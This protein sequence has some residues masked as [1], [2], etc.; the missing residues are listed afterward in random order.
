MIKNLKL[1]SCLLFF[2][3]CF[4]WQANGQTG[5]SSGKYANELVFKFIPQDDEFY[6]SQGD[7]KAVLDRLYAA[8]EK[9]KDQIKAG[10][11]P[12]LVEGYSASADT[13]E[14]NQQIAYR[15]AYRVKSVIIND[16]GLLE[17]NFKTQNKTVA[18]RGDKDVVVVRLLLNPAVQ[19]SDKNQA[20]EQAYEESEQQA[21][22]ESLSFEDDDV[23]TESQGVTT[24]AIINNDIFRSKAGFQL[25]Q[26]RFQKRGYYSY[27]SKRYINGVAFNDQNRGVFNYASIGALNDVARNGDAVDN[28]DYGLFSYGAL[29][30]AENIDMRAGSYA[31]GAKISASYTNRTYYARTMFTYST[32]LMPNGWAFTGSLGARYS[33]EGN[34]EGTFYRNIAYSLA[35]EKQWDKGRH[36]LSF[37]TFG[38]PVERGQQASSYL[39]TYNL[40]GNNLYNSNWG[41]Q[42]GKKRN[43]RIV[44]AYDPTF[45]L[46]H[47]WNI[48]RDS[49]LITG[50]GY[51]YGR[52]GSTSLNWYNGS[53]PRPDYYRYL[54]SYYSSSSTAFTYYTD[55]WMSNDPS[56]TQINWDNLYMANHNSSLSGQPAAYNVEERR[57]DLYETTLNSTLKTRLA[58]NINFVGGV[59]FRST[60]SRQFKT[61][62]DLLGGKYILDVDKFAEA[63][64]A[65][66]EDAKQSDLNN[67]NRKVYKG[68]TYGYS[69]DLDINSANAWF[70]NEHT[71]KKW[72]VF[73]G[74]KYTYTQFQ[75]D[76]K[77]KNGHY[78]D[79]SLGK[80]EMHRFHD[81]SFKAGLTY[82]FNGRNFISAKI[83]YSTEA[84]LP[85]NSYVSPRITD[86]TLALES[87]KLL[88][89]D[90]SYIFSFPNLNGRISAY[91]TNF[92][93][94]TAR[95]SYYHD[96]KRTFVNHM[97]TGMDK[98][99]HGVE[100]GLSWKATSALTFDFAG[101]VS[102]Q[103]Y[104]NNPMG[105]ITY[106]NGS[107]PDV[108]EK[109]Y[110]KNYY[111]GGS[112]QFIGTLGARY[113]IK[114][115]FLG[116]NVNGM[117]RNYIDISPLRRMA[118]T[119][120]GLNPNVPSDYQAYQILT[121]Q[122]KL[123]GA[124]TLDASIGKILYLPKS[125]SMSFNLS[126][127]NILN[128][129][130]I[131]TGG[132][133][134]GRVEVANPT[135]FNSKYFFMQGINC[136]FN[137]NYRF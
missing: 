134:Q 131:R 85:F 112:P 6:A 37:N 13:K 114:Y 36:S 32:G 117:D 17:N 12:V 124:V 44:R 93:D 27:Y 35:I 101:T 104:N 122:E 97:V 53:D 14:K 72:D 11:I 126:V 28:N 29:G 60:I 118:S 22:S 33:D 46:S 87:G 5:K 98:V 96:V 48:N 23:E 108:S 42:N 130:D 125:H 90:V 10:Q 38:S 47:T 30:G 18:Y 129:K 68:D 79:N 75:R 4:G 83:S 133:E 40:L 9:Y 54:P 50:L 119:Y 113:F 73:Y 20:E 45:I 86:K 70:V 51:H 128:K 57:S 137:V 55:K 24:M 132:Y 8:I 7:N 120:A 34:I 21:Q 25:S 3:F 2:A 94:Q 92:Y 88:T 26:F 39:E 76:G 63:S 102:E 84:P 80:G 107:S 65:D 66:Y 59:E 105:T 78:P 41:Y 135:K 58:K 31:K 81:Y 43:S 103:Y 19:N 99:S 121:S 116:L 115:W 109:V 62:D 67:P 100:L 123:P 69:F 89:G 106:E 16:K 77:M 110:Y 49:R 15:R 71:S 1:A 56:V 64:V 74:G 95:V 136:F 61:L 127:N 82:K 91:Q 52:Y 111:V